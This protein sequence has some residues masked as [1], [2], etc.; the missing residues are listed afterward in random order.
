MDF[1]LTY[2][3][4]RW[5]ADTA[6]TIRK[7]DAGWHIAHVAINGDT[8]YEGAPILEANLNQD[9]V[10]FPKGVGAF[11]GF[12][13]EQLDNGDIDDDRAQQMIQEVGDWISAC[14][15]SQPVWKVWNS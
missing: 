7:I 5:K 13:W 14:E 11:L 9:H 12:V 10:K 8:D 1:K 4:R 6:L 2:W 3:T 15:T